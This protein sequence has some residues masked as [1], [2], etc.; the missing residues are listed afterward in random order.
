MDVIPSH[1]W[2]LAW[3]QLVAQLGA[4]PEH[5]RF[6]NILKKVYKVCC[7]RLKPYSLYYIV[8]LF[9]ILLQTTQDHPY[10]TFYAI[11]SAANAEKPT[12]SVYYACSFL[13]IPLKGTK[14]CERI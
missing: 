8:L 1:K 5:S 13:H 12:N 11:Y 9:E 2:L 7:N 14:R 4:Y 10:H 3:P 6:N